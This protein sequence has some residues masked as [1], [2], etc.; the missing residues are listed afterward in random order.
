MTHYQGM[1]A[2][3]ILLQELSVGSQV[4]VE[5]HR[6]KRIILSSTFGPL[7]FVL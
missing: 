3:L 4:D 7:L 1:L 6:E 5:G 2:G